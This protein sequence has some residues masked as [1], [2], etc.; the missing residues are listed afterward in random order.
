MANWRFFIKGIEVEEPIGWDGVEFTA[1]RMESHGIDQPFSTEMSFDGLGAKILKASYDLYFINESIPITIQSDVYVGGQAWQFQGFVNMSLYTERNVCDTDSWEVTVGI[2]DDNF[3]EKFK[4]RMGVDIDIYGNKDLDGNTIIDPQFDS[5]RLH[6]QEVYLVGFGQDTNTKYP[7]NV[8]GQLFWTNADGWR[9]QDFAAVIPAFITNTDFSG[10]FGTQFDP[11]QVKWD[12]TKSVCFK[13]NS[14]FERV[15]TFNVKIN[16]AFQWDGANGLTGE[17]AS[18]ALSI[19]VIS[20][21]NG[22]ETQRYYLGDSAINT[23]NSGVKTLYDFAGERTITLPAGH[24]VLIFIQWGGN[25]NVVPGSS[26]SGV[27]GRRLN[28]WTDRCCLTI[29]EKNSA[30]FA[31]FSETLR[32]ENFLKRLINIITG[33]PDGLLSNAFSKSKNGCYWN[34]ALTNGLKIRQSRTQNSEENNCDP[35]VDSTP[36]NFKVNFN[37]VFD[38]LNS[39]FC[40]GWAFEYFNNK[41]KIRIEPLEYFY[42]NRVNF[43]APNV[44]EVLRSAMTNDLVNDVQIGYDDTWKNIQAA[45]I[46]A[47]HTDRNYYIDNRAMSEGTTKK[48]EMLS[49]II[50]EGYA[51]EFSRRMTFFQDDSGSSDRPN[52]YELFIFWLNRN[53]LVINSV[54]DSE[55]AIKYEEGTAIFA[56]GTVSMSSDRITFSGGE[57]KS[58][59]NI[60]I[61]PA[62]NAARWWKYLGMHTFGLANPRLRFQAGEYQITYSSTING[63]DEKESCIEI[64]TGNISENSDIYPAILNGWAQA[65]L[66][67]PIE[68]EFTYPQS[69]CDF[70][71]LSEN[72]PYGKVKLTSGSLEVSGYITDISNKPE[73]DNG[74]TTTFKLLA[75]NIADPI[76]NPP[77]PPPPGLG[78]YN[79]AYNDAYL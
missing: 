41:W 49:G 31:T 28:L 8:Y 44:G 75:S 43:L 76:P 1:K 72:N 21:D 4:S 68:I 42:Q 18:V 78:P 33:D 47:I 73:D 19:Q 29:T 12:A 48:F 5:T 36:T 20:D 67:R 35:Y 15:L 3:R 23:F 69:L 53:E 9:L 16:G 79:D 14:T 56:P 64:F 50:A 52:D 58:L 65:Y 40:L 26:L 63:N 13:N 46:W 62:R 57:V 70:I 39:I 77:T 24:R 60:Y 32:V 2:L 54:Q 51:I 34:Y 59:Y 74:G 38:G 37:D 27:V 22:T 6:T 10:P 55:Y 7:L 11:Q 25:G 45:G 30:S 71:N 66:F 17:T 61:T